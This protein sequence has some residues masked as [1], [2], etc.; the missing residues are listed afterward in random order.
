MIEFPLSWNL[1]RSENRLLEAIYTA[2]PNAAPLIDCQRALW[3]DGRLP[4]DPKQ[5]MLVQASRLRRKTNPLGI[6]INNRRGLGYYITADDK[7]VIAK[8]AGAG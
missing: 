6:T 7:A 3:P 5:N 1:T 8:L 4:S 2:C